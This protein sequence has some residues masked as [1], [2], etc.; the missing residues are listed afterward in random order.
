MRITRLALKDLKCHAELDIEPAAGLT[1]IR[2]PNEAG[3]S[4]LQL[5]LRLALYRKADS[6][7]ADVRDLQRWGATEAPVVGLQM[8]A[9]G[10]LLTLRKRFAGQRGEVELVDG[11]D[12]ERDP[13]A[14]QAR[15]AELTGIPSEAFF[16][17]TACVGHAELD[18]VAG[19]DE[20]AISD[21]LQQAISG[22][23]R[24]TG[25]AKKKLDAAI[26]RYRAEGFKNPGLLKATRLEIDELA[27]EAS[28]GEAALRSLEADRAALAE[29]RARRLALDT[30]LAREQADLADAARA[31]ALVTEHG[32]AQQRYERLRQAAAL[33]AEADQLAREAPPSL[34]L[35]MLRS[36]VARAD[37]CT[38]ELSELEAEL[39]AAEAV[40]AD[41]DGEA[42]EV[43]PP[44]PV[45]WLA[46]AAILVGAA[47]A[48]GLLLGG[49]LGMLAGSLLVVLALGVLVQAFR[50]AL[51]RR[52]YGLVVALASDAAT[53]RDAARA[54]I[55][56]R[57]RRKR[58]ELEALLGE[59]GVEDLA[60]AQA[61]L[62]RV[63]EQTERRS[64]IEGELRGLGV[65]D[66]NLHR[67]EEAR[68]EAAN[69]AAK[70]E[71]ALAGMGRPAGETTGAR[72]TAQRLVERTT[73]E[74]DV[75]RTAE[76]QAQGRVD[77][78]VVDADVVAG[79]VE[80][81][82]AAQVRLAEQERRLRI[83]TQT[84]EAI[85]AAE[86]A[87]LK[88]AARY[89][90]EHMGPAVARL[91]D[92]RYDEIR[93]DEKS[94]AFAVRAPETGTFVSAGQLSQ[95]TSDQ[96]FLAARLGLVRLVTMD[97]RPPLILD[98]PFVTFD[99]ERADRAVRLLKEV[100]ASE[101]FQVLLLTCSE[102]FDPIADAVVVLPGPASVPL[103][104][105]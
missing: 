16:R 32:S 42:A 39:D 55:E 77:A 84:R 73:A 72:A 27:A 25:K 1:V 61:L 26:Q 74:R 65:E 59:I 100:A 54:E 7:A 48:V 105:A 93:V 70:A 35:G 17:A 13:A 94:L 63:E 53:R 50:L 80:R 10:R 20:P 34:P 78:N 64:H 88:T 23:D 81:L 96:L 41:D 51:R 29:A 86:Q 103:V 97:R 68:D 101:G 71:H 2:G 33:V 104:A 38:F 36:G 67:L 6:G 8:E 43:V 69:A 44:H 102:R 79:V 92:G 37:A 15:I 22:A 62:A 31:E 95:G 57:H 12:V 56:D 19:S 66:R 4:T 46:L 14:I 28:R 76:D 45:R 9:D 60:A 58:R 5:A 83:Y 99:A 98:D 49:S 3:K 11:D 75:A 82:E 90:E 85:E 24:G 89:L 91:T 47:G 40:G 87:T 30:R 52:R 21:R 18:A